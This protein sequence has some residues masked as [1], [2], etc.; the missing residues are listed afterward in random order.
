LYWEGDTVPDIL[1]KTIQ[2]TDDI[3][4]ILYEKADH[5][6]YYHITI[7][8]TPLPTDMPGEVMISPGDTPALIKAIT[9]A[10]LQLTLFTGMNAGTGI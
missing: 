8:H 10:A 3:A 4:V 6:T 7:K 2:A 5:P 9:E 1:L